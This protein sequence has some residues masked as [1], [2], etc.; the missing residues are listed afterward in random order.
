[1]NRRSAALALL[2]LAGCAPTVQR[3]GAP[4]LSFAGPRIEAG[5]EPAFIAHDGARLGLTIWPA[6][7]PESRAVIIGL[8]GMNDYAEAFALAAPVWAERGI[9]TYAYDQRGF[10]RSP[11]RGVWGGEALMVEDLRTFTRLVR[12]RHPGVPLAIVGESMGGAVAIAA[13]ASERRPVADRLVLSAPAVW[14]WGDQPLLYRST[15]WLGAHTIGAR[16]V[17]PP[18]FVQR[19]IRASD[20]IE[21]LRRMG[22]DPRMIFRTRIDT[23]YGLVSL[24][25]TARASI[26][27]MK[28]PPTLMLYGANDDIIPPEPSHAAARQLPPGA[29]T[30]WYPAGFHMLTRDLQGR[31]VSEDIAAF[32]LDAAGPLPSGAPPIPR[33]PPPRDQRARAPGGTAAA[34]RGL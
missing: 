14:G 34:E 11:Q 27:R 8:H 1:V 23:I 28:A 9:A 30:A 2:S 6:A 24:M 4:D 12:A 7:T 16:S 25:Q 33:E 32:V 18:P 15:L 5:T 13:Y 20:N 26:G 22:R 29:R 31:L 3:A 21:H 19:R 17:S 10:G